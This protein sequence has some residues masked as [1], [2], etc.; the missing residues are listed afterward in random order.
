MKHSSCSS[1]TGFTLIEMLFVISILGLLATLLFPALLAARGKAREVSCLSNLRQIGVGLSLY[2][3]DYD[4]L[5][6]Y[7]VD[8]TDRAYPDQW[9]HIPDFMTA[10]PH[11][12][13]LQDA[14][15]PD[16][17]SPD[18]WHCPSDTGYT[19]S[20][21]IGVELDAFPSG[22]EKFGTSYYYRTEIP[23]TRTNDARIIRPAEINIL[24]DTSGAWHAT[25]QG[26][27]R[28]NT[29]F[30]DNHVKNLSYAQM[31]QAWNTPL[32]Q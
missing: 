16:L 17:K 13:S 10:V 15:S 30:A 31:M 7:A 5:Y 4:G 8:P 32:W 18:V 24:C 27:K 26:Y 3:Q 29:L 11:L 9:A 23:A 28:F 14:L 22:F 2:A 6:P 20:D 19:S 1:R 12:P 21:F 25:L